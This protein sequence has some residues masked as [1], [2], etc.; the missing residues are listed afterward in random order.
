[1]PVDDEDAAQE[2]DT[3]IPDVEMSA[4]GSITVV[5]P[6]PSGMSK[7]E[8][9]ARLEAL[10]NRM[11]SA[12]QANRESVVDEHQKRLTSARDLAR[13]EK[14]R[15]LAAVL[16]EKADAEDQGLDVERKKNWEYTIEENDAWERRLKRKKGRADFEFHDDADA[17]RKKYKKDL[18]QLNPD[19]DAYTRQKEA[20]LGLVPGALASSSSSSSRDLIASGSGSGALSAEARQAAED[21]YRDGNTLAY[22]DHK[23]SED[24]IDRVISKINLDL[25]K[26]RKFSRK[27]ADDDNGDITYINESNKVFNKKI[28][29]YYDKYTK[30]IRDSFERGTAL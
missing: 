22:G 16:R 19:L 9:Q 12:T 20:A 4:T 25:D 13:L 11:A 14:Q 29:R 5:P 17:A 8:R 24:A 6:A 28:A 18:D 26:K 27:R 3:E 10:R 30:E 23:P 21:L 2:E 1:M 15:Q 7:E